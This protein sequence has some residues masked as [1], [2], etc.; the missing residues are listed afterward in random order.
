MLGS[1]ELSAGA[2]PT[3]GSEALSAAAP[4]PS[5]HEAPTA[6]PRHA[7]SGGPIVLGRYRLFR[8]LGSGAFATVWAARDE[9]L[10]R[11]V[12]VKILERER[13]LPGRFEREARAAAR[14]QHPAIVTLYEAAVDDEG[15]YLVSE[16]VRGSTLHDLLRRGRLSDRAILEIGLSLCDALEHAHA[17]GVIHR[18]L[19]P[20]NVLVPRRPAG[21]QQ[22][23]KLTDFGVAQLV[24]GDTLT[25]TGELI[26][27]VAYMSP[28]QA[29]GRQ[30]GPPADLYSLALVLYEAL[31]GV[32][33]TTAG[34]QAAGRRLGAHL[35]P[36]R[37]QRRELPRELG[38]GIDL[39]LRPRPRERGSVEE[40]RDAL[41]SALPHVSERQGKVLPGWSPRPLSTLQ[42]ALAR[43]RAD[44]PRERRESPVSARAGAAARPQRRSADQ[45]TRVQPALSARA[46][47]GAG[48][49][50]RPGA[51]RRGAGALA[52]GAAAAWL[53]SHL[54]RGVALPAS[55]LALIAAIAA[56][57][58]PRL[59]WLALVV[60]VG[61]LAVGDGAAGGALVLVCAA[62]P[63][64]LLNP[65]RGWSWPAP[66]GAVALGLVGLGG[67]WPALA[68]RLGGGIWTRASLGA[69]GWLWLAC[70]GALAG[71]VLYLHPAPGIP[72]PVAWIGAPG[73]AA[74]DVL[75]NLLRSGQWWGA[76]AWAL[77][78][79]AL[80]WLVRGVSAIADGARVLV[81][82][83]ALALA[84]ILLAGA[85]A[86]SA[87]AALLG[88]L[89]AGAL[90]L[91]P[92]PRRAGG[93]RVN[94]EDLDAR[95]P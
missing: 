5:A 45:P 2:Q 87:G 77:G 35:P 95:V 73:L 25:R 3:R 46:R 91:A 33:P 22:A 37:R 4:S 43:P 13:I 88:A 47:V 27:T 68:G 1:E 32:N 50:T 69:L 86:P 62:A 82:A 79:A 29:E 74:H 18:D 55:V 48:T 65:R 75:A 40:L 52:A 19:K 9:R 12:A 78:A 80:P 39:A 92:A 66:A 57:L 60:V 38:V 11:D 41:R 15:A 81:W 76:L 89:G 21:P 34:A 71:R 23:G 67:A 14:L 72:P 93:E 70:A 26:G 31:S 16:L 85:A 84:A 28:E 58:V 63:A 17:A 7:Q 8:R 56:L 59:G 42:T 6:R 54:L 53:A 94:A 61:A 44:L 36:L 30:A 90:A 64:A 20:S 10:E 49:S 83:L 51:A 24:G